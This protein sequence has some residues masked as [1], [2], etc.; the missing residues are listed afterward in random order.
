MSFWPAITFMRFSC[1]VHGDGSL[2]FFACWSDQKI[3]FFESHS[4]SIPPQYMGVIKI[5]F[6][7]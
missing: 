1:P 7:F 3:D 5:F 6:Y 2:I 4:L